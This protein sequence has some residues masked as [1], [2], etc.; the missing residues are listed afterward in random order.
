M[1]SQDNYNWK[2]Q[3]TT[4]I[5]PVEKTQVLLILKVVLLIFIMEGN[6]RFQL[7]VPENEAEFPPRTVVEEHV[8]SLGCS[9]S[10]TA[11]V[12]PPQLQVGRH[13]TSFL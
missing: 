5:F 1:V 8:Q 3:E 7:T 13:L 6:A 11:N 12:L 4:V 2:E 9:T 10:Y